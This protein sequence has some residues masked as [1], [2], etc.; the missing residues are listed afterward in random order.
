[1]H[2]LVLL[3]NGLLEFGQA[4]RPSKAIVF[5]RHIA[6]SIRPFFVGLFSMPPRNCFILFSPNI[7]SSLISQAVYY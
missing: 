3:A 1:M 6:T 7:H 4:S 5:R 2:V